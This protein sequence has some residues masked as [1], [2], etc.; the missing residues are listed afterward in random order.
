MGDQNI[1][2]FLPSKDIRETRGY[3]LA[4]HICNEDV[5]EKLGIT[6]V[7]AIIKSY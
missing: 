4:D 1:A 2:R 6:D 5:T 7:H 3:R